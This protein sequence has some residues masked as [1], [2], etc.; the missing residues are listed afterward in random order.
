MK[1]QKSGNVGFALAVTQHDFRKA[2][3]KHDFR[4]PM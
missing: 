4:F 3:R 1:Q 2:E